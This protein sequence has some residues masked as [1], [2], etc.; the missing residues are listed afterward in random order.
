MFQAEE[1][2][3]ALSSRTLHTSDST[4]VQLRAMQRRSDLYALELVLGPDDRSTAHVYCHL[5]HH[6]HLKR[7]M[8]SDNSIDMVY[9]CQTSDVNDVTIVRKQS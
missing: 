6:H 3:Q 4:L 8:H 7:C 9:A 2:R 5:R 1:E